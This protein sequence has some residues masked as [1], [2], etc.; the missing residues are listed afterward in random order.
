VNTAF[1]LAFRAFSRSAT[2]TAEAAELTLDTSELTPDAGVALLER[3][4]RIAR[5]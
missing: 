5:L 4:G 2:S 3:Q 1:L